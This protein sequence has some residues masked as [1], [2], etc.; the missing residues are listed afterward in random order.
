MATIAYDQ[1][2]RDF[3]HAL[4]L[5][6]HVTNTAYRKTHV[7]LHHNGG[8]LSHEGILDVWRSRPASAHFNVD[9]AGTVGQFVK[10]NEYAWATGSTQGNMASISIEMCNR[11]LAPDWDV[12]ETTWSSA[13]R[14]AG[15]LFARV[16]GERPRPGTLV[17]HK[18]WTPTACAG[19]SVDRQYDK[20]LTLSQHYYDLF[21]G[22]IEEEEPVT[23]EQYL[24]YAT[25]YNLFHFRRNGN[26][27]S[28]GPTV[29]ETLD[30]IENKLN[31]V[32]TRNLIVDID[33]DAL[34]AAL[35]ARGVD[36]GGVSLPEVKSAFAEVL[37]A[38]RL[39]PP[40]VV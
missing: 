26:K 19:P 33:E 22:V 17:R 16:I 14:L 9:G 29:F 32:L 31:Q 30:A 39:T 1:P 3:I 5:T 25:R 36:L 4:N 28:D 8:R 12:S 21:T 7:T 6:G 40:P 27:F 10:V 24:E 15:W 37:A 18:L 35:V 23:W 38:T 13:A 20:I 11:S 2:V 34:A